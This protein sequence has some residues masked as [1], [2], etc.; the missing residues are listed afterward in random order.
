[1]K[2]TDKF[3]IEALLRDFHLKPECGRG[4]SRIRIR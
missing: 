1:M 2:A 4:S 3:R